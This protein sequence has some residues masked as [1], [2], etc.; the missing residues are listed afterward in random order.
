[1]IQIVGLIVA[2]YAVCRLVQIGLENAEKG[3]LVKGVPVSTILACVCGCGIGV[4]GVLTLLL[5]VQG[6]AHL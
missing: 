5:L 3:G 1:M 2:V 6:Q 4:I